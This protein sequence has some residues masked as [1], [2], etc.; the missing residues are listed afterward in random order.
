MFAGT[1]MCA[2]SLFGFY[3]IEEQSGQ[4]QLSL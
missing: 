4:V 3:E 1:F 2:F